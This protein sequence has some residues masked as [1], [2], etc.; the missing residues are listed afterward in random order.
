MLVQTFF[1][2]LCYFATHLLRFTEQPLL[3]FFQKPIGRT[4]RSTLATYTGLFD[5]VRKLFAN[6][7]KAK[8]R[9]WTV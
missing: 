4:P 8:Q 1:H 5:H 7:Q 2:G 9:K 6:T 3:I